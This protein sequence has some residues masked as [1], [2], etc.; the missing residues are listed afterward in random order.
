VVAIK[1]MAKMSLLQEQQLD[2]TKQEMAI[3]RLCGRRWLGG[4]VGLVASAR[5]FD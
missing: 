4:W 3:L 1:A 5:G 2:N